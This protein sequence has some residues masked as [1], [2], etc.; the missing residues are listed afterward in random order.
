MDSNYGWLTGNEIESQVKLGTIIIEPFSIEYLNSNSY[1]YHLSP[2]IKHL[3][4]DII[5]LKKEDT[6]I[7]IV[8]TEDGYLLQPGECYL[9]ATLETFGSSTFASLITGRSS[10]GRKFV[11]NH[12]TAGLIDQ[13]FIGNITLEIIVQKPT[14]IYPNIA[15]GQIFWFSVQGISRLYQGKYQN[16]RNA[17]VSMLHLDNIL[18][19]DT[20]G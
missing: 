15:F 14:I 4:N 9:G 10:I 7:E 19:G 2:N 18:E 17:T 1:N 5:D 11:T 6:Y 8:L 3:T 16:Q 20:N 13:G 12:I